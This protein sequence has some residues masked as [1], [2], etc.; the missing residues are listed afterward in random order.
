MELKI[1]PEVIEA[2]FGDIANCHMSL[3][4]CVAWSALLLQTPLLLLSSA[5]LLPQ[6]QNKLTRV[7]GVQ[8]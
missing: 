4:S 6:V 5:L 1:P 7:L 2:T 8:L 3:A